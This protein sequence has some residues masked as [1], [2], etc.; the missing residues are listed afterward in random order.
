M[1][2]LL[3]ANGQSLMANVQGYHYQCLNGKWRVIIDWYG[4]GISNGI[5]HNNTFANKN[6]FR[7]YKF[8]KPTLTVPGERN[9]QSPEAG[10]YKI[11]LK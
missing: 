6:V 5:F 4:K 2:K 9:S 7:E 3:Q 10:L 1:K 11:S 8:A